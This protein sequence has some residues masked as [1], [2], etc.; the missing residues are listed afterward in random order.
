MKA[1]KK[2][3]NNS[4]F[5]MVTVVMVVFVLMIITVTIISLNVNQVMTAENEVH[6]LQAQILAEGTLYKVI[7]LQQVGDLTPIS[8]TVTIEGNNYQ[9]DSNLNNNNLN[10]NIN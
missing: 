10:I 5:I 1:I 4:G 9:I 3:T 8:E 2:L 7:A 6:S